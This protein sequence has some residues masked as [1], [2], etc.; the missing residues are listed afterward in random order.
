MTKPGY[1]I[2]PADP[3]AFRRAFHEL[4]DACLERVEQARDLPWIPKP[5]DIAE[6]V[7][8][9]PDEPGLSEAEVFAIMRGE[10]MPYATG[11]THPR[12]FGWVHGTGQPMGVAAEMV[13]ATM[14]A[15]LGGRDHGA[16]AVEQAVID[17]S[18]RQAGLPEGASGVLTTGTSQ[19]TILAMS[20]ARMKLFG[21]AVRKDGIAG[22]GR[23]RVYAAQGAHSCFEKAMEVMGH[24][25]GAVRHIPLGPDGAMDMEALEAAIAEDRA[26]RIVPMAVV[27][28][29]G[30]VNTGNFDRLD[31]IAGLCRREGLWFHVDGAFGF[32]AVLAEDPWCDLVKG[33]DRADSIAADFHKWIGVP[34]DCGMV[35]M[36]DGDL[37]R[38]TFSTR[39]A[40]LEGQVA[41]LGGGETWFTDYGLELSRG[42]R[43]LKVWAGIK[44]AGVPALSA[45]I[46]DNCRQ[47]A[48]MAELVEASEVLEMA[49]P[50]QAN[51]CCFHV[52][53]GDPS[54]I[55]TALQLSGEAVFS[56][57]TLNG[58][59][60]LRAAIVNHRTTEDD[61]RLAVAAVER[62]AR[63]AG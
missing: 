58:R 1:R 43:A 37:H 10:V 60:C 8:L 2:D 48:L 63:A 40:Y 25:S 50:V 7:A 44:A 38:R 46:S 14:N 35:L 5:D 42:F 13:A 19:A 32:W 3:E 9:G 12:F 28:T 34:Y 31:A 55:A 27:G 61:V 54:A 16:M 52:T 30:S 56:T 47:A 39:P 6:T 18:R 29:A 22:L 26:D 45:T 17:W 51:V 23:I 36:R 53:Q 62:E 57:T 20:A 33:V 49:Q 4:A 21:D 59:S 11:N 15:N 41:G 24:G